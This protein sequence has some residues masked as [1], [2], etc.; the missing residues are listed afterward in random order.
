METTRLWARRVAVIEP[1][2]VEVVAPHLCRS[3]YGEAHWD[4]KQGAVYGKETV[5]CGG[6][7][8]VEGRR[9]H[10][11]RVDKKAA[12]EV[13]LREGILG[14][15]LRRK[16]PFMERLEALREEIRAIEDKLRRPGV[17]WS[18]DAVVRFFQQRIPMEISTAAAFHKWRAEHEDVLMMGM[19]D[20]VWE[21]LDGLEFFPDALRYGEGEYTVYYH[22][23]PGERDDGVTL[24]VHVDQLPGLPEWLPAWGVDGNLEERAELLM[25]SLP[26]DF[27][28]ACQ[29]IAGAARA[30]AD[31]W[32]GAP[33]D[34]PLLEALAEH[35]REYVGAMV[36]VREFDEGRLP[37]ELVTKIWVCDD[38]AEEL[39]MGT[40]VAELKL[41]LAD[42]MRA[43]FEAVATA[44]VERRGM[45]AWDGEIL[46]EE[47]LTAGGAVFPALLDEGGTVGVRAFASVHEARESH[48]QGGA[49]LLVLG[50]KREVDYL[51]KKF[52]LGML[53]KVEMGRLGVGGTEMDDLILL[54]AEGAAGGVFPRSPEGFATLND[55]SKGK[56]YEAATKVGAA[57]DDVV[58]GLREIS[59]W[60]EAN[61]GD[62]NFGEIAADLEEE[63]SW[64]LRG[65]F[66]WRA[67]YGRLVD[68]PRHFRAMKSRLGR[69]ASL[70]LVKDL[71]KMD[72]LRGYWESWY[73]RWVESP[74]DAGLWETGWLLEEWR[75]SLFAP[76]VEVRAKVSEKRVA[77]ALENL[78][79]H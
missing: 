67:G 13:F 76:D 57:L 16:T 12:N 58:E 39:A 49:R 11:G 38:D 4:E 51:R 79:K 29:P 1:E 31:L 55:L 34:R 17:L 77:K 66:A 78:S 74:D 64:L 28:R 27:R 30:F 33:K 24:G 25:R 70:P 15:G 47:V 32:K 72:L 20:V 41:Q 75:V 54:A 22:C 42:R 52:P 40:D 48:R 19:A 18:E 65:R 5:I 73:A 7:H 21:D 56:W 37:E 46:P 61:R 53:A 36:P 59:G 60:I 69:V 3:R 63:I 62:R 14:D 44:D 68:Y 26:K 23:A 8:V 35:I 50:N 71:E 9:V 10:Y 45:T 6:L 2:W 43:R